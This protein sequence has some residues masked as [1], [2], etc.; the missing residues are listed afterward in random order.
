MMGALWIGAFAATTIAPAAWLG[1]RLGVQHGIGVQKVRQ[2]Q[3][4]TY[5]QLVDPLPELP[6]TV[7]A[8]TRAPA[9]GFARPWDDDIDWSSPR[10][11]AGLNMMLRDM[12]LS[13]RPRPRPVDDVIIDL[14]DEDGAR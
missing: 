7:P 4:R 5:D 12:G 6:V 9:P 1:W 11:E 2:Q 13:P 8:P 14:R 10:V 3:M